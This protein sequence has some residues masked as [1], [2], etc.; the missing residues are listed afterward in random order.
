MKKFRDN[1]F[2]TDLAGYTCLFLVPFVGWLPGPGG[3]PL[4]LTGLGLLSL[5]NPW[6]E[7]M[8]HYVQTHSE[9][10]RGIIFPN[11]KLVQ[12]FWDIFV[13]ALMIGGY[14]LDVRTSGLFLRGVSIGMYA[15][16]STIFMLNR[17]RL[18]WLEKARPKKR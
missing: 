9:S 1:R 4:L 17:N 18:R 16:A 10:L 15:S 13:I 2:A 14:I 3:I 6:A 11:K 8:L 7:K 5:N 12:W